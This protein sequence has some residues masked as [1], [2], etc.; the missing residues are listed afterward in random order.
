M[1]FTLVT[2]VQDDEMKD[3]QSFS[4]WHWVLATRTQELLDKAGLDENAGIELLDALEQPEPEFRVK[5]GVYWLAN[6]SAR[7]KCELT[8]CV[9]EKQKNLLYPQNELFFFFLG[10]ILIP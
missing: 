8:G 1:N 10:W 4:K 2:R 5:Y 9:T 3:F 7:K 6:K